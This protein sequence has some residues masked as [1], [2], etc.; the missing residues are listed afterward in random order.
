MKFIKSYEYWPSYL[1]YLP[2]IPYAIF[3]AIKAKSMGFF[4]AINPG[5]ARAGDGSESKYQS[6]QLIPDIFKPNT[7]YVPA[8]ST[9]QKTL[10]NIDS[11]Q[12]TY[13][14]IIKPDIGFRGLL[15]AK[16]NS[17]K[18]L[19]SYLEKYNTVDLIIQ[20]YIAYPK[21]CGLF[22]YKIPGKNQGIISSLTFKEFPSVTGNG[23]DTIATLIGENKRT[24]RYADLLLELNI[25]QLSEV[26]AKGKTI[27][28]NR[29]GNH[30]KGTRFINAN[31]LISSKLTQ[32]FQNIAA[33]I[34][35]WDYGRLDIKYQQFSD[36]ENGKNLKILEINGLI[37]EPTHM[38][39]TYS[40]SYLNC[41]KE[42]KKHWKII[43]TIAIL[44]KKFGNADFQ[45][46]NYVTKSLVKLQNYSKTIKKITKTTY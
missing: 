17:S 2:L 42:L 10:K 30:S 8:K 12:L 18:A 28:L 31:H 29:I 26:P 35:G 24:K 15:V 9:A 34:K 7:L 14:L 3:L 16:I 23:R 21:E 41:L 45:N 37:S 1:F 25:A 46:L 20:E 5:I 11:Q 32:N 39:D 6:I 33:K 43:Y 40:G 22:F 36:L 27:V 19:I 38:Y 4:Y 13:P 44:N